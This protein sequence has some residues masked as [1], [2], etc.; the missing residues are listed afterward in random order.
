MDIRDQMCQPFVAALREVHLVADPTR[1]A[2]GGVTGLRFVGRFDAAG[3]FRHLFWVE[4]PELSF[5]LDV[6][7]VV[8]LLLPD[9]AQDLGFRRKP[10]EA[11]RRRLRIVELGEKPEAIGAHRLRV[12]HP[13]FLA[14]G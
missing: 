12:L 13:G 2:L 4:H 5:G 7:V 11:P 10:L 6:V 1:A 9:L 3:G 14:P 8:V